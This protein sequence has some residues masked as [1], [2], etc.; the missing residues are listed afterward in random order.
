VLQRHSV[1][2][3]QL[4]ADTG[5]EMRDGADAA[6]RGFLNRFAAALWRSFRPAGRRSFPR[7]VRSRS[8]T[9]MRRPILR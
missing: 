3:V 5:G 2:V 7:A 1:V 8:R 6:L 4:G 9:T